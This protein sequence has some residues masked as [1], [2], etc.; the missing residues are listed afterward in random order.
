MARS[1]SV[2]V[3]INAEDNTGRAFASMN[4]QIAALKSQVASLRSQLSGTGEGFGELGERIKRSIEYM[5]IYFGAHEI[6]DGLKD[7]VTTSLEFGEQIERAS[8]STGL[9]IG[10]LST[11]HYAAAVTGG[12]FDTMTKAVSRMDRTIAQATQGNVQASAYIKSLGLD[13]KQL[14]SDVNGPEVAFRRLAQLLGQT[15]SPV[16]RTELASGVLGQRAGADQI[17]TL[18]EVG[19]HWDE[20]TEKAKAAGVYLDNAQAETLEATNQRLEDL[21]QRILGASLAFTEG[22]IPGLNQMMSVIS[23]STDARQNLADWGSRVAKG[24]AFA[25]EAIYS[26]ASAAE[27]LFA[28]A[29]AGPLTAIGRRDIQAA[30]DLQKKAQEFHDIAFGG[31]AAP[32]PSPTIDPGTGSGHGYGGTGDLTGAAAKMRAAENK[33][34]AAR[35][36]LADANDKLE[37]SRQKAASDERLAALDDEHKR[38]LISDTDFYK[39]KADAQQKS[40]EAEKASNAKQQNDIQAQ[41]SHL[42]SHKL[43]GAEAVSRDAEVAELQAKIVALQAQAVELGAKEVINATQLKTELAEVAKQKQQAT[44]ALNADAERAYGT[45]ASARIKQMHDAYYGE[46]GERQ[47]IALERPGDLPTA[48]SL[49]QHNED[50]ISASSADEMYQ[51][52]SAVY[53]ANRTTVDDAEARGQISAVD[54]QQRKIALD[55]EEAEA[56]QPVL[57][58]YEKLAADG[59]NNAAAKVAELQERISELK[60]PISEVASEIRTQLND[61]LEQLFENLGKGKDAWKDFAKSLQSMALKDTYQQFLQPLVQTALG[62]AVPNQGGLFGARGAA[63]TG[64]NPSLGKS[65]LG[66]IMPGMAAKLPAAAGAKSGGGVT[67]QIINQT[68]SPAQGTASQQSPQDGSAMTDMLRPQVIQILLEDLDRGGSFAQAL[69]GLGGLATG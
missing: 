50:Q 15:S 9:A 6:V 20:F 63:A 3:S 8:K 69:S 48:D 10:T 32:K 29:E 64:Q 2:V 28:A 46:G 54:A 44:D 30:K 68:S 59:D 21:K 22:L 13:A 14:A 11:L 52:A 35:R 40:I 49:E 36:Q 39:Q 67:V 38:E 5:G 1:S 27:F 16:R 7:L 57:E 24:M 33:L 12:D 23:G 56:L 19:N 42:Q 58:A 61:A 18:V 66:A 37:A 53:G 34:A 4:E 62:H 31:P 65:L 55:R 41:I 43:S 51:Q 60:S 26:T 47:K 45:G 17:A 25:A